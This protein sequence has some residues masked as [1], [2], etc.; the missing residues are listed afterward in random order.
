MCVQAASFC[1]PRAPWLGSPALAGGGFEQVLRGLGGPSSQRAA[2]ET[3]P[4][5]DLGDRGGR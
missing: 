5:L 4:G 2:C 3:A 1:G